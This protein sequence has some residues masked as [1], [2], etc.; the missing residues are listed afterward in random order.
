MK[1][2]FLFLLLVLLG[3]K[4]HSQDITPCPSGNTTVLGQ[5]TIVRNNFTPPDNTP[6]P[7]TRPLIPHDRIVYWIHG[8]GGN[9][10][11]WAKV[12]QATQYQAPT[13]QVP[14]YP[15][16]KVTSLPLTYSE[17]SLSG[18]AS[19]LHNTLVTSGDPACVANNI[20]DKT[21]NF[22]IA[23]SQ[24]GLVSRATDKMYDELGGQIERRFGG[25]VTFG[26]PHAGAMII[27]NK[28]QI[29]S[30]S[31]EACKALIVG[32]EAEKAQNNIVLSFIQN[33]QTYQQIRDAICNFIGDKIVPIAFKDQLKDLSE[34]YKV[35][36][37]ALADLNG[38]NSSIPR[39]AFYGVEEE[40]VFYRQMYSLQVKT[41]NHFDHFK[42]DDDQYLVDQF[43]KLL[44]KY[45]AK[46]EHYDNILTSLEGIGYPCG[47]IE[48][49][50]NFNYCF[51]LRELYLKNLP[52]K[53]AWGKGLIW[54]NSSNR[55]FKRLIGADKSTP[56]HTVEFEN[57]GLVLAESAAAYP[58]AQVKSMIKSNHQQMRNDSNTKTRLVELFSGE[59][60]I[61]FYTEIR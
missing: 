37:S 15:A 30:F 40:P 44:E 7:Q 21:Q 38:H 55:K 31:S 1:K 45:R 46:Y 9:T 2:T 36:S 54:L 22:I 14:G 6:P 56:L 8:L 52:L 42:A 58:G 20:T 48:W 5:P 11:S 29:S 28:D 47:D 51:T 59:L 18:A 32:P 50:F 33:S 26:T 19:T 39:V 16:R 17:F 27:K 53:L 60:G 10:D 24:G 12:A 34:D 4:S 41:P 57:D 49:L 23:H 13:Q 35:G 61:Y 3:I 25:I 43:N